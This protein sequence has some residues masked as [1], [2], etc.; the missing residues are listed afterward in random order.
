MDPAAEKNEKITGGYYTIGGGG[1]TAMGG[2]SI[3]VSSNNI[4]FNDKGQFTRV[5]TAEVIHRLY[6]FCQRLLE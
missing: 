3:V 1:N 4:T 6:G 2:G 5:S